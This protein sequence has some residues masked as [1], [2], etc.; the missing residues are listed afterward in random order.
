MALIA[1]EYREGVEDLCHYGHIAVT[2]THGKILWRHGDP[3]RITFARSSA[4]PIQ[5]IPVIESGAVDEYDITDSELAVICSSHSGERFHTEAVLSILK[6]SQLDESFLQC[7]VHEPFKDYVRKK[8][9][10]DMIEPRAVHNNCSG[11]HAGMLITAKKWNESLENYYK[12]DHPVQKHIT[13]TLVELCEYNAIKLGYDGCG[14]PVHAMPLFR[15]AQGYAKMSVPVILG[16]NREKTV[17]KIT[18][19][20]TDFPE[21]VGGSIDFTT[22]LMQAF[23]DKLFGKFGANAFF[24]VGLKDQGVGV[25]VKIENG[26]EDIVPAVVLETLR[27][28]GKI[29]ENE[30][31]SLQNFKRKKQVINHRKEVVGELVPDFE[32]E[33]CH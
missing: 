8:Y 18:E 17:R 6:K 3:G 7:G 13:K 24:A 1:R 29:T 22:S 12:K 2:D 20:M 30:A 4:K 31:D 9:I 15:F 28:I 21:M 27:Q 10:E 14:A 25:A 32:L 11:K 19:A 5:A 16:Q 23:K 26:N 33:K